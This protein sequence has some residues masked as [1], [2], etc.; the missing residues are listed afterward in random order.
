MKHTVNVSVELRGAVQAL[1]L[2]ITSSPQV[3]PT[4][5]GK[6]ER[7]IANLSEFVALARTY[8]ERDG[9]KRRSYYKGS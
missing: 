1:M 5:P 7:K 8:I 2:P 9:Y 4:I 6:I 3:A